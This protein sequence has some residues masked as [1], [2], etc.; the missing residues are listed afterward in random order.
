M[1]EGITKPEIDGL[2][3]RVRI[4]IFVDQDMCQ[5]RV[6]VSAPLQKRIALPRSEE[7]KKVPQEMREVTRISSI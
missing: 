7:L 4:L 3:D 6:N 5:W 1:W 2:L